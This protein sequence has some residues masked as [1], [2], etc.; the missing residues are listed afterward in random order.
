MSDHPILPDHIS[1][2]YHVV[3]CPAQVKSMLDPVVIVPPFGL[4]AKD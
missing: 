3:F 4:A 2:I 1:R